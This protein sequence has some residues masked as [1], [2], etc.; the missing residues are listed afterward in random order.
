MIVAIVRFGVNGGLT[1]D[2]AR[3][4]FLASAPS[5]QHLPGL[6]RKYYLRTE[7]GEGAGGVYLWESREAAERVY[8]DEWRQ[9]MS[10]RFGAVPEI[11]YLDCPVIV[12]P[13][14]IVAP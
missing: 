1:P 13:E 2:A 11:E 10:S 3:E 5:Y 4:R 12:D 6:H 7:D 8:T 9:R 14:A